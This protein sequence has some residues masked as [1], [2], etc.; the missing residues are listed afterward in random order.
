MLSKTSSQYFFQYLLII[1]IC[2]FTQQLNLKY[3]RKKLKQHGNLIVANSSKT[4]KKIISKNNNAHIKSIAGVYNIQ[5]LDCNNKFVS[6]I[7]HKAS[8][9]NL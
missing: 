5:Y 6:E 7:S 9:M 8:K 4:I 1:L 3:H 2:Y